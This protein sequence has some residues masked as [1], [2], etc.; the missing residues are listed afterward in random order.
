[1]SPNLTHAL[2]RE[3]MDA[4]SDSN[5]FR[6]AG[7]LRRTV[8]DAAAKLFTAEVAD[9]ES[10]RIAMMSA[11]GHLASMSNRYGDRR[12]HRS[13]ALRIG[14]EGISEAPTSAR[15]A[16]AYAES[17]VNWG[18]D[19]LCPSDR[20][21]LQANLA[22]AWRNCRVAL[23]ALEDETLRPSLLSQWS[24][25]HRCQ[26][27]FFGKPSGWRYA[28]HARSVSE[29][30]LAQHPT[31]TLAKIDSGLTKWSCA[32]F[33]QN[34]AD[35]YE[36]SQEAENLIRE[37]HLDGSGI[38]T[39]CLARFLRQTYRPLEAL[40]AFRLYAQR[41]SHLRLVYPECHIVGEAAV[42]LLHQDLDEEI[43]KP[44]LEWSSRLLGNAIEAGYSNARLLVPLARIRLALGDEQ[45]SSYFLRELMPHGQVEWLR[46]IELAREALRNQDAERL[47]AAFALGISDGHVWN[48]IATFIKDTQGDDDLALTMYE[49]AAQ[50]SPSS[51]AIHTNIARLLLDRK[52]PAD[53]P[54]IK[55]HLDRAGT[56][57]DF[58]FRWW[59]PLRALLDSRTKPE[60]LANSGYK[61]R[62]GFDSM[63]RIY[64]EFLK[65]SGDSENPHKRGYDFQPLVQRL[66]RLTFGTSNVA[67][68]TN[69]GGFQSDASFL[70]QGIGYRV[71]M[72]WD[73]KPNDRREV[74]DL[75]D[76]MSRVAGTR[77]LLVSMSG[78]G[79]GAVEE[80]ARLRS[81]Q[82][83]LT[84]DQEE[85]KAILQGESRLESQ[86]DQKLSIVYLRSFA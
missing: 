40:N 35:F 11:H 79:T 1:M 72:S 54:R 64:R 34:E 23:E 74:R 59:R 37:A 51:A 28:E 25:A 9:R 18:Y 63:N 2:D 83:I 49:E 48:S 3:V 16:I 73:S 57:A 36:L 68:S 30:N 60:S 6:A 75:Y 52:N 55:H 81:S 38:A 44:A 61:T 82:I 46:A 50:L 76:R 17:V 27:A 66:L 84:L 41:E 33:A 13:F 10:L 5:A 8:A 7:S 15:L 56:H 67:G 29:A 22:N 31:S 62:T 53:N 71:E 19:S 42:M 47:H 85:L 43:L 20:L 58:A 26:A 39:I 4:A 65:L 77:G 86:L 69:L 32:R 70:H 14:S 80:I 78:F 45:S 24:S 12:R 21:H